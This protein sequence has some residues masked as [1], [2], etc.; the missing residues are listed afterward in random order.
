MNQRQINNIIGCEIDDTYI[1]ALQSD[2]VFSNNRV[3]NSKIKIGDATGTSS[4]VTISNNQFSGLLSGENEVIQIDPQSSWYKIFTIQN[5]SFIMQTT[6]PRSIAITANDGSA[7]SLLNIQGNTFWRG[8]IILSYSST[9]KV[10][11]SQNIAFAVSNP[12]STG[13]LFVNN[14]YTY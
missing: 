4:K 5:N 10:N 8:T 9:M 14:N 3:G 12:T 1:Y 11:Y 6:N 7:N 2:F 13:N